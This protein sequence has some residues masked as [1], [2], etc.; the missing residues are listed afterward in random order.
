MRAR[1]LKINLLR[2]MRAS[3]KKQL[4]NHLVKVNKDFA[5]QKCYCFTV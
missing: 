3:E 1:G 2:C 4:Y 5:L